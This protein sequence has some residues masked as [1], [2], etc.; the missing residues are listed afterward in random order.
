MFG[1]SPFELV[2]IVVVAILVFGPRLPQV[3]AEAGGWIVKLKRTLTDLR[4]ESGIDREI[5]QVKREVENA[6]PREV[7]NFEPTRAIEG[8]VQRLKREVAEP[9]V[10]ALES[11]Q[12]E[13]MRDRREPSIAAP[14]APLESAEQEKPSIS[15]DPR[16]TD[17]EAPPQATDHPR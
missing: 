17:P 7:R 8:G 15:P 11:V 4:R 10:E 16:P 12:E 5:A 2:V 14:G 1:L 13:A 9:V 6:I 3:A